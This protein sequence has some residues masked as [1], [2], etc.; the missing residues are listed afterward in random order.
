MVGAGDGPLGILAGDGALPLEVANEVSRNGR[1]VH[2][3]AI[4]GEAEAAIE[5]HPHTWIG[6]GQIG[7]MLRAFRR[8]GCREIVILGGVRRPDLKRLRADWGFFI[9]LPLILSLMAGG[10]DSVLRRIVSF[11]ER[12]GFRVVGAHEVAPALLANVGRIG[13]REPGDHLC[14]DI[15]LGFALIEALGPLDVGQGVVIANGRPVAIEAAEG[16]DRMLSRL[17]KLRAGGL[18]G[19]GGVL[20]KAPKPGQELRIDLPAVGPTTVELASAAGLAGIAVAAGQVLVAERDRV[21]QRL[22]ETGLFLVGRRTE[23]RNGASLRPQALPESSWGRL[24]WISGK[25][26]SRDIRDAERAVQAISTV[27]P[28]G[29]GAAAVAA[30][31]H[32]LALEA[33]EGAEAML[34]R[35]TGLRQWGD[36]LSTRRG[37]VALQ[38]T[39]ADP[40]RLAQLTDT[41]GLAG[42]VM[43]GEW[44][45]RAHVELVAAASRRRLFVLA[46]E[47]GR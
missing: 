10:D 24:R 17:G 13:G 9:N 35:V 22:M 37:F 19:S 27:R 42:L 40:M 23:A 30:R 6:L 8:A 2:V 3:V 34:E 46:C 14:H 36:R 18:A 47:D 33:G 41:A 31:E 38:P 26:R 11:F 12:R 25:V 29:A 39:D 45:N 5:R 7:G 44:A 20:V 43:A 1:P 28:F 16:T 15:A 4:A 32:V 21:A